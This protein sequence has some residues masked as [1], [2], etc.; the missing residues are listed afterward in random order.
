[1]EPVVEIPRKAERCTNPSAEADHTSPYPPHLVYTNATTELTRGCNSLPALPR[2][3]HHSLVGFK[4]LGT[5]G[6]KK[7]REKNRHKERSVHADKGKQDNAPDN[8]IPGEIQSPNLRVWTDWRRGSLHWLLIV[9][10]GRLKAGA[11]DMVTLWKANS[12]PGIRSLAQ[13]SHLT[14]FPCFHLQLCSLH[15]TEWKRRWKNSWAKSLGRGKRSR[16]QSFTEKLN[17]LTPNDCCRHTRRSSRA[18]NLLVSS[19]LL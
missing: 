16:T 19:I 18:Q 8:S 2:R 14:C 11:T 3:C 13:D 6:E 7:A 9:G 5:S 12:K 10:S 17:R 1:M 15:W 4:D